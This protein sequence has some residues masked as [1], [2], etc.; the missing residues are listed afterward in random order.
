[1]TPTSMISTTVMMYTEISYT[2]DG[3]WISLLCERFAQGRK[4][5]KTYEKKTSKNSEE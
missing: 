5:N 4:D 2:M 3:Q 1:M